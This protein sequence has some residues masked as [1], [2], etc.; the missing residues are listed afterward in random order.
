MGVVKTKV[1]E[2]AHFGLW[3]QESETPEEEVPFERPALFIEFGDIEW[4]RYTKEKDGIGS[5][6]EGA[7]RLHLVTDWQ[8]ETDYIVPFT[9]GEKLNRELVRIPSS[10]HYS[11]LYPSLT[12]TN[13]NHT[14]LL[15]SVEEYGVRFYRT[16]KDE[17]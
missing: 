11:V 7:I 9:I 14:N 5:K 16:I 12:L 13:H 15:E 10:S 1:P 2:I 8:D 3:N 4:G 17:E 6:G